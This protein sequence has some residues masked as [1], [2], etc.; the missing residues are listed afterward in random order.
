MG[1]THLAIALGMEAIRAGFLAYNLSAAQLVEDLKEAAQQ[2]RLDAKLRSLG[3]YPLLILDEIGYLSMDRV[4]AHL[5][6]RL[7]SHRY[8]KGSTIFT[9]NKSYSEWG[10]VLGDPVIAAATLDRILHHSTTVNIKGESYRL[11]SRRK[12]GLPTPSPGIPVEA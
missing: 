7:V 9:S 8:E 4:G 2:D 11:M 10:E 3:R 6:F 5:F 12:A 1:E